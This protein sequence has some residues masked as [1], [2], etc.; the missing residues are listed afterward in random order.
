MLAGAMIALTLS[1]CSCSDGPTHAPTSNSLEY[2]L[3]A[4]RAHLPALREQGVVPRAAWIRKGTLTILLGRDTSSSS[5]KLITD[6]IGETG[7]VVEQ[8][9]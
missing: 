7:V 9:F 8:E 3:A 4:Y 6:I 2:K 5:A 1:M